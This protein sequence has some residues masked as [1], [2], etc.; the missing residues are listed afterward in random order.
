MLDDFTDVS[1]HQNMIV[2]IRIL[3]SD[4]HCYLSPHTYFLGIESIERA[5]SVCIYT[6]VVNM[7]KRK[8]IYIS[9]L[10][11]VSTDGAAVMAGNKS[12]VVTKLKGL[13]P[14]VL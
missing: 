2:Y 4:A 8:G 12:G 7:L 6:R 14:G 10:A 1:V 3:E 5:N 13:V 9:N 11:G